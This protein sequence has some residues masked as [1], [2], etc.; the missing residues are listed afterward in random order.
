MFSRITAPPCQGND[1]KDTADYR[2]V[3]WIAQIATN[4]GVAAGVVGPECLGDNE[5]V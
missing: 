4:N 1:E 2:Q 5:V 3:K